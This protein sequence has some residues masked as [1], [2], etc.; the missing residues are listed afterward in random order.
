MRYDKEKKFLKAS[1]NILITNQ[2]EN[3]EILS[4]EI[5]YDKNTEKIVSSGNVKII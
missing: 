1:G 5:T 3:M 2:T 4:D